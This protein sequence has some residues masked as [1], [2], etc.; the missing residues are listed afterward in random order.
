MRFQ[1]AVPLKL[2]VKA[3]ADPSQIE[4]VPDNLT[5]GLGFTVINAAPFLSADCETQLLSDKDKTVY[6][7]EIEGD[8]L[9]VN[10]PLF[11]VLTLNARPIPFPPL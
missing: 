6:E 7:V 8:T 5:L 11:V 4:F 10:S 1:G 2:K 3:V 9:N